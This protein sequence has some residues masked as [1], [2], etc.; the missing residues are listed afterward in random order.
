MTKKE[1]ILT[2]EA[3]ATH[4]YYRMQIHGFEHDIN[5]Y[6]Y[7]A[8][9]YQKSPIGASSVMFHKVKINSYADGTPYIK[10]TERDFDGKKHIIRI[11]LDNFIRID[12]GWAVPIITCKELE[13][14]V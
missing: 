13:S 7:V 5:D 4:D 10:I 11:A 14:I 1:Y 2:H 9:L 8:R 6:A 12:S 3:I